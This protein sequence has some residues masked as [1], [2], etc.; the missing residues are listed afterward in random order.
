MFKCCA[1]DTDSASALITRSFF[2]VATFID[3]SDPLQIIVTSTGGDVFKNG[4]GHDCADRR[5]LSGRLRGGRSRKRQLH[6]D[7]VQQGWCSRY[8]LGTNGSKTGK[9]LS[10]SSADVDTKATFMVVVAL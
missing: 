5:L 2:D 4:Q 7:E 9:T 10:V 1:Q 3:N 6:L 8:L